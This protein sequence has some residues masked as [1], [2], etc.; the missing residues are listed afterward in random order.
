MLNPNLFELLLKFR[1]Y[2]IAITGDIEKA[3]LQ[4]EVDEKHRD[5][6]RFLRYSDVFTDNPEIVIYRFRRVMF[7]ITPSQYLLNAT[8][9][10][11]ENLDPEFAKNGFLCR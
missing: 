3:Y 8:I 11:Y 4:I 5:F 10:S 6:R 9:E 1:I 7:G 2:P